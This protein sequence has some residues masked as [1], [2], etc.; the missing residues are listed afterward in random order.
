MG[1]ALLADDFASQLR[2]LERRIR[3]LESTAR[4]PQISTFAAGPVFGQVIAFEAT[5]STSWTDLATPG[6]EVTVVVGES[7]RVIV[8]AGAFVVSTVDNQTV[9]IGLSIDGSPAA[10]WAFVSNTTGGGI[11]AS[12]AHSEMIAHG[13]PAT[14]GGVPLDLLAGEH[15]FTLKYEQSL[16]GPNDGEFG[17]RYLQVQ[18]Y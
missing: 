1:K 14:W 13:D 17:F 12:V 7:R 6:P 2:D 15:T 16:P 9:R 4:V 3:T 18:P 5:Q 10:E 8:T 11:G